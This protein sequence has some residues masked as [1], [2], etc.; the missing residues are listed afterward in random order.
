MHIDHIPYG[1]PVRCRRVGSTK[2]W[3]CQ[4]N[5][6]TEL[7]KGGYGY[8]Y[9]QQHAKADVCAHTILMKTY[10]IY[11]ASIY[12]ICATEGKAHCISK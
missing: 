4:P 11:T 12:K 7:Q 5:F 10:I 9:Q 3:R 2:S 6:D 8:S 1:K